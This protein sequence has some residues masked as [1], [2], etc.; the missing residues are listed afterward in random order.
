MSILRTIFFLSLCL[1]LTGLF[2]RVGYGFIESSYMWMGWSLA[3]DGDLF[4]PDNN[5][6]QNH[7]T[8]QGHSLQIHT[9]GRS[10]F[11]FPFLLAGRAVWAVAGSLTA[12][13]LERPLDGDSRLAPGDVRWVLVFMNL[14]GLLAVFASLIVVYRLV[15]DFFDRWSALGGIGA[16]SLGTFFLVSSRYWQ[17]SGTPVALLFTSLAVWVASRVVKGEDLRS[18]WWGM[19][20]FIGLAFFIRYQCI[21]FAFLPVCLWLGD[22][23]RRS[24]RVSLERGLLS[25]AGFALA[26]GTV[27]IVSR[28]WWG[29]WFRAP[30]AIF[31]SEEHLGEIVRLALRSPWLLYRT[32]VATLAFLGLFLPGRIPARLRLPLAGVVLLN[33]SFIVVRTNFLERTFFLGSRNFVIFFPAYCLGAPRLCHS[34]RTPA[35]RIAIGLVLLLLAAFTLTAF[36]F[37]G[38]PGGATPSDRFPCPASIELAEA[39]AKL[40]DV[41]ELP[42]RLLSFLFPPLPPAD[43]LNP[44]L[45]VTLIFLAAGLAVSARYRRR[46]KG[47]TELFIRAGTLFALFSLAV[48][49][50]VF[51]R[52]VRKVRSLAAEGYY[53]DRWPCLTGEWRNLRDDLQQRSQLYLFAGNYDAALRLY[54]DSLAFAPMRTLATPG[55]HEEILAARAR[56]GIGVDPIDEFIGKYGGDRF[57]VEFA[58]AGLEYAKRAFDRDP[59]TAAV[60]RAVSPEFVVRLGDL[61][62]RFS[63]LVVVF[64]NREHTRAARVW[65]S[66][67]GVE[68]EPFADE[69]KSYR[70][71]PHGRALWIWGF[72]E[73]P[74][75]YIKVD[76]PDTAGP[77]E[78][79]EVLTVMSPRYAYL[80]IPGSR[81]LPLSVSRM[82]VGDK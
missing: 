18:H 31:D 42:S 63:D 32:P 21:V 58:P 79:E 50:V 15:R 81:D 76:F 65:R 54:V 8:P 62:P 41:R 56:R 72:Y 43:L 35:G 52:S 3:R 73:R 33:L 75:H 48:T 23:R 77:I 60:I 25:L 46:G 51:A 57:P 64:R 37:W 28:L 20:L 30:Q 82:T 36:P 7:L 80:K 68:W 53:D 16:V 59:A 66:R 45:V 38:F 2:L 9:T 14:S 74:V 49:A 11:A 1:V 12:A 71:N 39:W 19:G 5:I 61:R 47:T 22:L 24:P 67:D 34:K 55:L 26:S 6:E 13:D 4:L 70:L 69:S 40:P 78:I 27:L 44:A 17:G 10:M 29:E